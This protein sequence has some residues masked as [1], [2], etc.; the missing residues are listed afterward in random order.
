MASGAFPPSAAATTVGLP[1]ERRQHGADPALVAGAKALHPKAEGIS[2]NQADRRL[3]EV[4]EVLAN[5]LLPGV[6][7]VARGLLR[8]DVFGLEFAIR[9]PRLTGSV[10]S[11]GLGK[12][13]IA[14]LD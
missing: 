7:F 12:E 9:P 6:A 14:I 2:G 1:A 10:A 5:R 4:H 8:R 11:D 3:L 13:L